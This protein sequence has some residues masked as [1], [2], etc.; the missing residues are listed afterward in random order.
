VRQRNGFDGSK[1]SWSF[2]PKVSWFPICGRDRVE[3]F[4][5]LPRGRLVAVP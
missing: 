1:R 3:S 4:S 2:G 5:P